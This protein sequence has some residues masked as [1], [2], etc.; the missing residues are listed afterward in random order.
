VEKLLVARASPGRTTSLFNTRGLVGFDLRPPLG[1]EEESRPF[2]RSCLKAP[3]RRTAG[4]ALNCMQ[5]V[6]WASRA[7]SILISRSDLQS[8]SFTASPQ[9][10]Q[11]H[12]P[13][14]RSRTRAVSRGA[15]LCQSAALT[16]RAYD[17]AVLG[18]IR[19]RDLGH[20]E[21]GSR[22]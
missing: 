5:K 18:R 10:P 17:L 7:S 3:T 14:N 1:E 11:I 15:L 2:L 6:V 20:I 21:A 4:L 9:R 22:L 12:R 13:Q 19:T 16:S 8:S